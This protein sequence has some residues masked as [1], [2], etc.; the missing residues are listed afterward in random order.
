MKKIRFE[1]IIFTVEF[2]YMLLELVA[3][4]VLS[5]YFGNS[6]LVWTVVI[7]I[8]LLSSSIGNFLGGKIADKENKE[9]NLKIILLCICAS[10]LFTA[11][12]QR[13]SVEILSVLIKSNT[14][15][16]I[17]TTILLF[18][19][20]S[21][22]MGFIS[23]IVLKLKLENIDIAG[24]TAGRLNAIATIGGITG[25]FIGGFLLIPNIVSSYILYMLVIILALLVPIVDLKFKSWT[26]IV[27]SVLL[28]TS[29]IL[30]SI[31]I[32]TNEK[33]SQKVLNGDTSCIVSYDTEYGHVNIYNKYDGIDQ[34]RILQI[35]NGY[36][37]ATFTDNNRKYDLVYDYAKYYDLMFSSDIEINSTLMIGG[38]G[39]SYPKYFIS[40][41]LDKSMDVVEI[42]QQITN[43]AKQYFYLDTLIKDYDLKNSKRLNL[44]T[45]DGRVFLNK[46]QKKYDVI[47]NDAF[48]GEIPPATLTTIEAIS[49]IKNSLT[50]GGIYMTNIISSLEG[51]DSK[52][53]RAEVNT[54]NKL[55]K[56]VSIIPC[57]TF[58]ET[59]MI[60]NIM[61]IASDTDMHLDSTYLLKIS[62]NEIILTDDY[63]PVE[64]LCP[65]KK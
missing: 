38:A 28:I 9:R 45:E 62:S 55:F 27:V 3:S 53:L 29:I 21:L 24:R 59:S 37:S 60:Q 5:P 19:I 7:G 31:N 2:V 8:I 1:I 6:N 52:F 30:L 12:I 39:Y 63:C 44:I 47:L 57:K 17:I 48:A 50:S 13:D 35:D 14:I 33:N 23:P 4:R 10:I 32:S 34:I 49:H 15:G 51:N 22:C 41:H 25:T 40:N 46:N 43:I 18:F 26:N 20:P 65:L 61:V 54:L 56:Y 42:D 36:E 16:S 11:I 64:Q 58:N